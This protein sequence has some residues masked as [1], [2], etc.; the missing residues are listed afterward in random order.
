[1]GCH[2]GKLAAS[3]DTEYESW[4]QA[5]LADVANGTH[6]NIT[7]AAKAYKVARK[8]LK[9][10]SSGLHMSVKD[11]STSRQILNPHPYFTQQYPP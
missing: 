7:R 11:Y 5:A 6:K 1:M 3:T 9:D 8:T 2:Q 10:H 4:I